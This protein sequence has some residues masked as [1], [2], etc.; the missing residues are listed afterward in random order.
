MISSKV[1]S[2]QSLTPLNAF[3]FYPTRLGARFELITSVLDLRNSRNTIRDWK[4]RSKENADDF[5]NLYHRIDA[6][7]FNKV[8]ISEPPTCQIIIHRVENS[9]TLLMS[10][11]EVSAAKLMI[12][13]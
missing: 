7:W 2:D 12:G 6:Q 1:M 9:S 11:D 10:V 13:R 5:F 8:R 4:L 3:S